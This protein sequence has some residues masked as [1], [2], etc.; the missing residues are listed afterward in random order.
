[1]FF[2]IVATALTAS[3]VA[4]CGTIG[5]VGLIVPHVA[6]RLVGSDNRKII[7]LCMLGGAALLLGADTVSRVLLPRELPVGV[8]TTLLGGPFFLW[9]FIRG[10]QKE[11]L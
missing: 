5:F 7:P 9:L 2:C 3:C 10:R 1:V 8:M 4:V 11:A 6:R